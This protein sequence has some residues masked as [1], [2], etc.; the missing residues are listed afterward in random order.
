[1]QAPNLIICEPLNMGHVVAVVATA[2]SD[3]E[4][5]AFLKAQPGRAVLIYQL[6]SVAPRLAGA[7]HEPATEKAPVSA[8]KKPRR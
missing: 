8:K 5:T 3:D 2:M 6:V 4:V 7:P 1:M